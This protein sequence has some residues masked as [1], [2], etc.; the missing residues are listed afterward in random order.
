M[1]IT[2][3][4]AALRE[5]IT[6]AATEARRAPAS[7]TIVA[8]SKGHPAGAVQSAHDAGLREF[9]ENYVQEAVAK[10]TSSSDDL[11]W[12][13]IG[14]IQSNKT[15]PI[16]S[17]FAWAQT[18]STAAVAARLSS[19]RPYYAG[20]LQVCLQVRPEPETGRAGV[21]ATELP[22]LAARVAELPRLKLRGLMLVPHAGLGEDALRLE[23]RRA[24]RLFDELRAIGHDCD[25]LS[26]GMSDD[27][28]M[29]VGEGSTMVR[30]GTALFGARATA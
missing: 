9:G 28:E 4:L 3:K 16:A 10:I 12:H 23:F 1:D 18:V 29:A 17:H 11:S 24:R 8:V 7:V 14:A 30:V 13:F 5:R 22:A 25:T 19:Q 21:A 15:R 2:E 27:L 6:R 26:M 20:D